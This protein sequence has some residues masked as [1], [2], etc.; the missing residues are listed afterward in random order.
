MNRYFSLT[1]DAQD[2]YFEAAA[3]ASFLFSDECHLEKVLCLLKG[4][5][6]CL[7]LC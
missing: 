7:L 6:V 2:W 1:L 3:T 5:P 4:A